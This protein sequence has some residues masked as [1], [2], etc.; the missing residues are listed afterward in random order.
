MPQIRL[1]PSNY[2]LGHSSYMSFPDSNHPVANLYTNT[3]STTYATVRNRRG[4]QYYLYITGFNFDDVDSEWIINSFTIKIKASRSSSNTYTS[5][6]PIRLCSST[7]II[8]SGQA[9]TLTTSVQTLTFTGV[10]ETW[11]TIRNYG[12]N[13]GIAFP[14]RAT[15]NNRNADYYI[16]GVEI[17]VDYSLP[18]Y[19][20]VSVTNTA[21]DVVSTVPQSGSSESILEGTDAEVFIQASDLSTI[22]VYDNN[23][24]VTNFT[25]T[26]GGSTSETFHTTQSQ[27]VERQ[28]TGT[29]TVSGTFTGDTTSTGYLN[30]RLSGGAC[31]MIYAIDT[32]SIPENA[33]NI[34]IACNVNAYVTSTSS[35]ITNKRAQLYSGTTAMGGYTTIPTSSGT[36]AISNPGTWTRAQLDDARLKLEATYS[37]SSSYYLR[38]Y[39][40]D[41]TVTYQTEAGYF[42]TIQNVQA[43][44]III[45]QDKTKVYVKVNG[46]WKLG[47]VYVKVNGVW[48]ASTDLYIKNNTWIQ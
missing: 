9:K 8:G 32:S 26:A 11:E 18:V 41:F 47:T 34:S 30:L 21:S 10:T 39:G 36:F 1:V 43:D 40:V 17:L 48:K 33:K 45:I 23:T 3:D 42:Y 38:F 27:L 19:H 22:K 12:A 35:S 25:Y 13:F 37:G 16:Y 46:S 14:T 5:S 24:L 15:S 31:Y 4:T 2:T 6:M 29:L 44:H 20:S 28:T 7:T